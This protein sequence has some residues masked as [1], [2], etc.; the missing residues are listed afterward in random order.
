VGQQPIP[1]AVTVVEQQTN[2]LL[3][4]LSERRTEFTDNPLSLVEFAK[5]VALKHWDLTKASRLMLGKHWRTATPDQRESFEAEFLRTLLRYVVRAYGYYDDDLIKV[6]DY[7]WQPAKGGGWVLSR[8]RVPGGLKVAV[9]YRMQS[10]RAGDDWRLIDVR[11]EGISLVSV[12]RSEYRQLAARDGMDQLIAQ[13]A[14][15]NDE[16]LQPIYNTVIANN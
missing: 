5:T 1:Q 4:Q 8:V 14:A 6:I 3:Q 16:I 13:M 2:V 15:K 7:R 10:N 11:V 9:D 12:K